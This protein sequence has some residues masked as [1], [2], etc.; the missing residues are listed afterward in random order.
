MAEFEW[1]NDPMD[2]NYGG[3][4]ENE[5]PQTSGLSNLGY[6]AFETT[7]QFGNL[8]NNQDYLRQPSGYE[9]A[10]GY[11]PGYGIDPMPQEPA[12]SDQFGQWWD[13]NTSGQLGVDNAFRLGSIGL[14][15]LGMAA[16]MDQ[17]NRARKAHSSALSWLDSQQDPN[18]S[19]YRQRLADLMSDRNGYLTDVTTQNKL[20]VLRETL[21]RQNSL[22]GQGSLN[23]DQ[24]RA[25]QEAASGAYRDE[26]DTLIKLRE[27]ADVIAA[28][29]ANL[30][31]NA[32]TASPL[33][34]V[35]PGL[36]NIFNVGQEYAISEGYGSD[37]NFRT[38]SSRSRFQADLNNRV[39]AKAAQ[40]PA[41]KQY[42]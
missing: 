37:P 18:S 2:W 12:W 10:T 7:N 28:A 13:R 17:Q 34:A 1:S 32:P 41:V 14:S 40:N 36:S 20:N 38:P 31:A 24:V 22:Q 35:L 21:M 42:T 15:G 19:F 6:P 29:R 26:R 27:R 3:G 4:Y 5:Q 30:M 33:S 9:E 25:L 8:G 23:A 11:D 39:A 16:A